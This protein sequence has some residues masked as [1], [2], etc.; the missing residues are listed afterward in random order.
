MSEG[1]QPQDGQQPAQWG[2][3]LS[4]G[5][6]GVPGGVQA[7]PGSAPG[8]Q[9][10]WSGDRGTRL[11][12][13]GAGVAIVAIIGAVAFAWTS[14]SGTSSALGSAAATASATAGAGAAQGTA[15]ACE[16]AASTTDEPVGYQACGPAARDVGV[17]TFNAAA[18]EKT[19]TVTLQTNRGNVVFTA[20]GKDAPYT[21]Y[22]FVY[23][24]E[25]DYFN[26]TKCHRLTTT[27][28]YV[29][30]CGDPTGTGSG[31]P[32]YEFQD[33]NL[34]SLGTPVSG[35]VTYKAGMVAMAN[36]GPG[37][38]G[39]QFFLVY[40]DSPLTPNYTPFGTITQGLGIL[41]QVA[42]AG[43]NNANGTGDGAPNEPVEIEKVTVQ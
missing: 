12:W 3:S 34:A 39:S 35:A 31:G 29:L 13:V 18:A 26:T 14:S 24:A 30:Q 19:Y 10:G 28:I 4:G 42:A 11:A 5:G 36:A 1:P 23:L 32:G 43:S 2:Q 9:S 6:G 37:T 25:K 40:K 17:P 22:S 16:P 41:K 21:V 15:A 8:S 33:E 27:G 20:D 7:G 38:N